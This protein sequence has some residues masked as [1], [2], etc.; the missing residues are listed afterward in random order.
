MKQNENK[1]K[2]LP[3]GIVGGRA[4]RSSSAGLVVVGSD[5]AGTLN[6]CGFEIYGDLVEY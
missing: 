5:G 2:T 6:L 4:R 3:N 1:K